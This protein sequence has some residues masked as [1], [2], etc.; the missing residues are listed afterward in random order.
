MIGLLFAVA[1]AV[2]P[3][4]LPD[5]ALTPGVV[6]PAKTLAVI[7]V[8]GFTS[9]PGVRHVTAATKQAAFD[10]YHLDRHSGPFEIDHLI[11]LELGGSNDL[12]NLWPQAY[13][14]SPL[15]AHVKDALENRAHAL[16]CSGKV[17]LDQ[18]QH[19]IAAD[20]TAAYVKYVGPLP[21]AP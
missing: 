12:R 11:S 18:I 2:S 10:E 13:F 20:W 17:P 4:I 16:A 6:D 9:Q 14:T 3:P 1:L 7:C 8:R 21:V 5:A 19:D 15:N